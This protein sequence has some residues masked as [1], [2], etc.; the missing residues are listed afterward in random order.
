MA[1]S[2]FLAHCE[3]YMSLLCILSDST[4]FMGSGKQF[5]FRFVF[6]YFVANEIFPQGFST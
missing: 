6:A 1:Q 5:Y 4:T 2:I 3:S